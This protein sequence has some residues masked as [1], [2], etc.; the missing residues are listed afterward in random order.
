[1]G[2]TSRLKVKRLQLAREAHTRGCGSTASGGAAVP[3]ALQHQ[4]FSSTR[5]WA[6]LPP[7]SAGY[8]T[9]FACI[10]PLVA[11]LAVMSR[12]DR[13]LPLPPTMN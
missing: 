9:V 4:A 10:K 13:G 3:G 12:L 6:P 2:S 1:M 11:A 5:P 8:R 7:L